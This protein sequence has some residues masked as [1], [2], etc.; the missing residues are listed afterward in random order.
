MSLK[1]LNVA[2][3]R[4]AEQDA[5]A[6][7]YSYAAMMQDAGRAVAER[8]QTWIADRPQPKIT[9]LVGPGNNGG[10]GLVA[11]QAIAQ[12][13]PDAQ[14]RYYLLT[15]RD[16]PLFTAVQQAG[17]FIA[18]AEDDH[19][20]RVL[21][22]MVASADLLLDA[23]F[24]I[25]ARLP[26]R[27]DALKILRGARQALNERAS[28]R[29]ARSV[30]DPTQGGQVERP[31]QTIVLAVDCPSGLDCDTGMLDRAALYADETVTFIAAK[32]GLLTFPGA[33]AVG[34]LSVAP[35][36]M[37]DG[38]SALD[39]APDSLLDN[40]AARALLPARPADGHKGT[41]GSVLIVGGSAQYTGAPGLSAYGAY[42]TGAGLVTVAAPPPVIAASAA[43]YAE[44]TWLPLTHDDIAINPADVPAIHAALTAYE[45]LL[46]GPGMGRAPQTGQALR[47]LLR[48]ADGTPALPRLV[49]DADGLNLLSELADWPS[50]LPAET[51]LTPHPGE[52]ARLC[53]LDTAAVTAG[54]L[55]LA[56]DKAAAWQAI[57][58]LKGAHTLIAAPNGQL[59]VSPFKTDALATAGTG[60]VLAGMIGGLLAQGMK[61]FAAAQLAVYAH[62]LAGT[63]AADA[64]GG[65]RAVVAGDVAAALGTAWRTIAEG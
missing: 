9:I 10:D 45:A 62:G 23:L 64:L 6:A 22:N 47:A 38:I 24:G 16:D 17:A 32:P 41:F 63:L 52:M 2:A 61:P 60:D 34:R 35:L 56:R 65:G 50:L 12:L 20:H 43:R 28:A 1:I 15:R 26:I 53:G 37:P 21:R 25:G 3:V 49:I 27:D 33:G 48:P 11:G 46:I 54:R 19:D 13:R 31:P 5:D 57:V 40:E 14:V 18:F 58:V 51:V 59:A 36:N 8:A 42:H 44:P 29:R 7:G 30:N 4:Q 55:R 39:K